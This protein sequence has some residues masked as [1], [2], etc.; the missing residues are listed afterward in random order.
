MNAVPDNM[1]LEDRAS[2][3]GSAVRVKPTDEVLD[4]YLTC[5]PLAHALHRAA[6]A[7]QLAN[8]AL[9]GPVLDLGCGAGQFASMAL[10]G[11]IDAGV[12]VDA[13]ALDRAARTGRYGELRRADAARL[14]FADGQFQTVLAVSVLEHLQRPDR[15][16]AEAFRVLRPGGR[17]VATVVLADL[18]AY[19]FYPQLLRRL[20]A[21]RLASWYCRLQDHLLRHRSLLS[22]SR[23]RDLFH[24][25]GFHP[26]RSRPILTPRLT[27][28]WDRLLL[29]A[30]PYRLG[31]PFAWH[32]RWFRQLAIRQYR[33]SV[34][35]RS[36]EGSNL[37]L[38]AR[39]PRRPGRAS[40]SKSPRAVH[41]FSETFGHACARS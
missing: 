1:T 41:A 7:H 5:A 35:E 33:D 18:H 6:E 23:W 10:E 13:K 39:K 22:R 36:A 32:P 25:A 37:L 12:D 26:V 14:P 27:A 17:F 40:R 19:L 29:S 11:R 38:I 15:A 21:A 2:R 28:S 20:G 24:L 8:V 3:C 31:C 16:L 34:R 9:P 30:S 4:G